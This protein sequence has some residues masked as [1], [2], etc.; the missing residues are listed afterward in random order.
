MKSNKNQISLNKKLICSIFC[1]IAAYANAQV[2]IGGNQGVNGNST[3]LDFAGNTAT[4]SPADTDTTNEKGIIL[5]TVGSSPAYTV[6]TPSTNNPNN[7]T[8]IFDKTTKMIRMF[9]NGSWINL[10]DAAGND[11]NVLINTSDDKGD[12]V[13][14]GANTTAA[15]GVL[16]LESSDK[17]VILPHIKNPHTMVKSPYPGMLCYDT[18]SNSLAVFDGSRWNY[19]K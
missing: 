13:I 18:A 19:W 15:Q 3:I 10:S 8:F 2:S 4:E 9:E 7:G 14:I 11:T 17:A 1:F 12:G 16:V 5:P 6:V